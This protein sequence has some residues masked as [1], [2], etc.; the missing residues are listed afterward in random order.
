MNKLIQANTAGGRRRDLQVFRDFCEMSALAVRNSVNTEGYHEREQRYRDIASGY[1]AEEHDRF[2]QMLA[3]LAIRLESKLTD[4]LGHQY[5][6][7]GFGNERL[8]QFFTPHD[9]SLLTAQLTVGSLLAELPGR[10]FITLA[11]PACGSGGM[12]IAVA[13]CLRSAGVNYQQRL[14]VTATDLDITSVHMA[15]LQLSLLHIPARVVHG[16]TL[17]QE[18]TDVW[19]SPAH[20]IGGWDDRLRARACPQSIVPS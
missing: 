4:V 10:E 7:L 13:D 16:N 17:T 19:E 9:V 6:T 11:E 2:A 18:V 12:I 1:T 3:M 15:Y 8:G 20:V 5:M 14:H